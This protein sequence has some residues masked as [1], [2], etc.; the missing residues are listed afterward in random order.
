MLK[1]VGSATALI[2]DPSG[3][4]TER[5]AL[6]PKE[7]DNNSKNIESS[8]R[9]IFENHENY[10]WKKKGNNYQKDIKLPELQ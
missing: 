9:K 6:D 10:I 5:K 4:S 7:V 8:I 1:K 2:G 3:K